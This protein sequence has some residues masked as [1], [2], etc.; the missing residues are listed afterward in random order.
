MFA[1]E[2]KRKTSKGKSKGEKENGIREKRKKERRK[3]R[4]TISFLCFLLSFFLPSPKKNLF[5]YNPEIIHTRIERFDNLIR[6]SERN[7][8]IRDFGHVG[9][10]CSG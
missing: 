2:L 10:R 5:R 3:R 6:R 1:K 8:Q 4:M 7:L 9:N